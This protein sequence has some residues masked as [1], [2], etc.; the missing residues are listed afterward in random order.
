MLNWVAQSFGTIPRPARKLPAMYTLDPA[1]DGERQVTLRRSGGA[2]LLVT[3]YHV[4][5]GS[6]ADFAAVELL[7]LVLGD[8]PSGRLHKQLTEAQLASSTFAF[9]WSLTD[10]AVLFLGAE[11]SPTQ[12]VDKARGVLL[13]VGESI[14]RAPITADE[15][16][17]ARTQWLN[18]WEQAFTD[19]ENI[20]LSLS[21]AIALGDWRLFFLGRDQVR[22]VTLADVQ[23]VAEAYLRPSNRTLGSYLPTERRSARRRPPRWTW[24]RPCSSSSRRPLRPRWRPSTPRRPTSTRAR[25]VSRSAG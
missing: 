10:P 7:A 22:D 23:R 18:G 15:L 1:Q 16:Q 12:D 25:S 13:G 2:P 24:R 4:P 9:A 19:P 21:E 14:A 17:R 11:L 5:P 8:T 3:A 6:H 20:G